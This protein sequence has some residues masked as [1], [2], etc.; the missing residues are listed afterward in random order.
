MVAQR[1][2][3]TI[4]NS[5]EMDSSLTF[6]KSIGFQT[7]LLYILIVE[8]ETLVAWLVYRQAGTIHIYQETETEMSPPTLSVL[9]LY[10]LIY[11]AQE[12]YL[13]NVI[14]EVGSNTINLS[15]KFCARY[16]TKDVINIPTPCI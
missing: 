7:K 15:S 5:A 13:N 8:F 14:L 9:Y 3:F 10:F 6:F 1:S 11:C 12:V 2:I 16:H 4:N